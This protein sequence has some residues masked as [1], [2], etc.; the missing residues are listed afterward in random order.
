MFIQGNNK[1]GTGFLKSKYLF[2]FE[3]TL[4]IKS[5]KTIIFGANVDARVHNYCFECHIQVLW[6]KGYVLRRVGHLPVFKE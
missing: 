5:I 4:P 6:P 2:Q 1:E 3:R